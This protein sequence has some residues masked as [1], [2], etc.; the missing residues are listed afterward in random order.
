M[1][2]VPGKSNHLTNIITVAYE[3]IFLQTISGGE[4]GVNLKVLNIVPLIYLLWYTRLS[5]FLQRHSCLPTEFQ[6]SPATHT[7]KHGLSTFP[8]T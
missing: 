3:G 1:Q 5:G 8:D 6:A 4:N 2:T 7:L